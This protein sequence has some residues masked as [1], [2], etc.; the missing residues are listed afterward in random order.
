M[1]ENTAPR[2]AYRLTLLLDTDSAGDLATALY[3]FACQV[4]RGQVTT[5]VSGGPDSGSIYE[6]LHDPGQTHE[7]YFEQVREYLA[8]L[9]T[10]EA[11]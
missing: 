10:T 8:N 5:G 7:K 6:L 9:K 4:E 2:R 1:A 11:P 3:N